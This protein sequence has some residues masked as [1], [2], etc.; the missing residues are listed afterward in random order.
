MGTCGCVRASLC[1]CVY[2]LFRACCM[3]ASIAS[4]CGREER[5]AQASNIWGRLILIYARGRLLSETLYKH[6]LCL[7]AR[8]TSARGLRRV[9]RKGFVS[10]AARR[11]V[12]G[13]PLYIYTPLLRLGRQLEHWRNIFC[14]K[15][16]RPSRLQVGLA[17]TQET[18]ARG[19]PPL[20]VASRDSG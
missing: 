5:Q 2:L 16:W 4:A 6:M 12:S 3:F 9:A 15:A 14:A 1:V 8:P 10:L 20:S 13:L 17:A 7:G 11:G 18:T 19:Y